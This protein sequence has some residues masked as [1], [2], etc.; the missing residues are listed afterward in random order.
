[1]M[2]N[3][4]ASYKIT[5]FTQYDRISLRVNGKLFAAEA[6]LCNMQGITVTLGASFLTKA[7]NLHLF[8]SIAGASSVQIESIFFLRSKFCLTKKLFTF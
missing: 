6:C 4:S 3:G 2:I 1:M 5:I 8:P 7:A